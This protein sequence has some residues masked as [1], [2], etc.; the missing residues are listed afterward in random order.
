MIN[1]LT[2]LNSLYNRLIITDTGHFLAEEYTYY[3]HFILHYYIFSNIK[4]TIISIIAKFIHK[5]DVKNYVQI[6]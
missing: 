5:F 2:S 4:N 1:F 6:I 3:I